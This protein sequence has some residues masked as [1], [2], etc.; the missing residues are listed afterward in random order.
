[1]VIETKG[2]KTASGPVY[3]YYQTGFLELDRSPTYTYSKYINEILTNEGIYIAL[4]EDGT[5]S[6]FSAP[7]VGL[8]D[9]LV[10]DVTKEKVEKYVDEQVK[11][12]YGNVE[13]KLSNMLIDYVN[14][15]YVIKCLI[16][17]NF[18]NYLDSTEI[19]YFL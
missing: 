18:E 8:F 3:I 15:K 12:T 10:A 11:K 1:M 16:G 7:R 17:L 13:Y 14:N 4:N 5:L 2:A 19:L 9:N 6:A